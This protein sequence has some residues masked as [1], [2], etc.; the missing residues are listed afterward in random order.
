MTGGTTVRRNDGRW[1]RAAIVVAAGLSVLPSYRLSAQDTTAVADT[2][3]RAVGPFGSLWRSMLLPGWGQAV[4]ERHTVG[5]IFVAWESVTI[6]MTLKADR[7]ADHFRR[8]G[9]SLLDAK[10]QERE[11][12]LVLWVFNH[13]FSGAEAFVAA[14]LRDFPP[15]LK[16]RAVPGGMAVSLPLPRF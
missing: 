15:D 12:W 16:L 7:E 2:V 11:D 3:P 5:A 14:H 13:L 9:S 4:N 10:R 1:V 6:M 8:I